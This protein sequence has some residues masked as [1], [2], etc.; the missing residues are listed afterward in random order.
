MDG[1]PIRSESRRECEGRR[2]VVAVFRYGEGG[3]E[4][5][6]GA[7]LRRYSPPLAKLASDVS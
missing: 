7:M 5:I 3:R 1:E 4:F 2:G 6:S